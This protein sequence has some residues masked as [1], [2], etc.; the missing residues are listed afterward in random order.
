MNIIKIDGHK[1]SFNQYRGEGIPIVFLHGYLETKETFSSFISTYLTGKNIITID[2]PGHGRSESINNQQTMEQIATSIIALLDYL[3]ISKC[4]LYGHSMG[5]YV[6]Q[7]ITK[8][9]PEKVVLLGLLHSNVY[10]DTDEKKQNRLRE[11]EMIKQGKLSII[12]QTFMPQMVAEFNANKCADEI[13]NLINYASRMSP[14][15]VVSCLYALMNRCD[16]SNMLNEKN[17]IHLIGSTFDRYLS[18]ET[19]DKM[20]QGSAIQFLDIIDS[21]GHASFIEQ[22]ELLYTSLSKVLNKIAVNL[23]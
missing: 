7:A 12:V 5:G 19:I 3:C 23:N 4:V 16:N 1:L 15:G 11:I 2:L 14:E 17:P 20:A 13:G 22:P 9:I 21:C 6:A 18:T 8:T 10:A